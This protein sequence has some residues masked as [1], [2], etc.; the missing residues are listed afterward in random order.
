MKKS[1]LVAL[2]VFLATVLF[3]AGTG[4]VLIKWNPNTE[5][6]ISGYHVFWNGNQIATVMHPAVTWAG[7]VAMLEGTN[8]AQVAA[9]DKCTPPNESAK[10]AVTLASTLLF[11]S[12][13]PTVPT[14][15]MV[16]PQ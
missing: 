3:A 1:L 14:G 7:A 13:A 8:V 6:D 15:C 12:T 16:S 9:F 4:N 5:A 10:S 11:D 2:M